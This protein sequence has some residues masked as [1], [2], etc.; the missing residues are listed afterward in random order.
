MS[1]TQNPNTPENLQ[2]NVVPI[3][4]KLQ[5]SR[6][7]EFVADTDK[8][9]NMVAEAKPAEYQ[10][11]SQAALPAESSNSQEAINKANSK[12]EK[13]SLAQKI[14]VAAGA[15]V[16]GISSLGNLTHGKDAPKEEVPA[17]LQNPSP[18]F[19]TVQPGET[20]SETGEQVAQNINASVEDESQKVTT[21]EAV[22]AII[23]MN[24]DRGL[25]MNNHSGIAA[26]DTLYLP[27]EGDGNPTEPGYQLYPDDKAK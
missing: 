18:D 9:L 23:Q 8:T 20:L 25:N 16:V 7:D 24:N 4:P 12:P 3:E 21:K 5:Q 17:V 13:L 15:F 19:R 6:E 2:N 14:A 11:I 1:E 26:G 22:D 27:G 10:N